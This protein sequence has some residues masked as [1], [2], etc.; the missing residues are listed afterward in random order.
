MIRKMRMRT[1]ASGS[2]EAAPSTYQHHLILS[3]DRNNNLKCFF[4]LIRYRGAV[5][6]V[7]S[8]VGSPVNEILIIDRMSR[9]RSPVGTR[10]APGEI[11]IRDCRD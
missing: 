3:Y 1:V 8:K 7:Q 6:V 4:D 11:R 9:D 5:T 2:K 10:R